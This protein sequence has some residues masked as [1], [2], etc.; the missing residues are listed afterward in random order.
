MFLKEQL[1]VVTIAEEQSLSKA[2]IKLHMTQPALSIFL[3]NLENSLG[4]P[5]FTRI[6]RRMEPTNAGL[7]YLETARQMLNLQEHFHTRLSILT[8]KDG[9]T[10]RIGI[11]RIR[12]PYMI[13]PI[14]NYFSQ[15]YPH[16]K[17]IFSKNVYHELTELLYQGQLDYAILPEQ[18]DVPYCD[19]FQ[20]LPFARD[21]LLLTSSENSPWDFPIYTDSPDGQPYVKL[22]DFQ[23]IP[24]IVQTRR[25]SIYH[26]TQKAFQKFHF[27][28]SQTIQESSIDTANQLVLLNMGC[29]FTMKSYLHHDSIS[30]GLKYYQIGCPAVSIP[31]TL[32]FKDMETIPP[33]IQDLACFAK[34]LLLDSEHTN[35]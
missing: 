10:L 5:L 4:T 6:N 34:K 1:Y 22:T 15:K 32:A 3:T 31:I 28:P 12:A 27:S 2:A 33:Y 26:L 30:L 35:L 18:K 14:L 23:N 29:G 21:I 13:P 24:L 25:Q 7:L 20:Y 11:Q 16:I 9:I 19:A 8:Q 17:L